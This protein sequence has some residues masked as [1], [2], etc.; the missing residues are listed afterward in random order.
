MCGR[1]ALFADQEKIEETFGIQSEDF[2]I[3]TS[4]YNA[5]PGTDLPV[6]LVG[7]GNI[8]KIGRL[9]WGL[10]PSWAEDRSI[11]NTMINARCETLTEKA[12]F[13]KPF[14]RHRCLIPASGFYEWQQLG[15]AK[16]PYFA[17][18]LD[19]EVIGFAGLFEKWEHGD[20][21]IYS[22][23][24]ITTPANSLLKPL[25]ERMPAILRPEQYEMW[26]DPLFSKVEQLTPMLVPYPIEKMAVYRVSD[27]VNSAANN[28]PELVRPLV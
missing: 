6:V 3:Y 14:Q 4:N 20:E 23:T 2:S 15:K 24:I 27:S 10:I 17:R 26:L 7:K 16:I 9:R 21:H 28:D 5:A 1:Y 8:R 18:S 11:G 25:H 19:Q 12:S 22:F 13:K